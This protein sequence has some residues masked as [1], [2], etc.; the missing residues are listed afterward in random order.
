L[1][2][3]AWKHGDFSSNFFGI[4]AIDFFLKTRDFSAF[5]FSFWLYIPILQKKVWVGLAIPY[6]ASGT[7]MDG[8]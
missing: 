5:Y 3:H 8:C 6:R 4:M 2:H 7:K 1:N